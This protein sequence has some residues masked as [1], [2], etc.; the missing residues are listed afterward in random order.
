MPTTRSASAS[1]APTNRF[2]R[3]FG[4]PSATTTSTRCQVFTFE[5]YKAPP[6]PAPAQHQTLEQ[7]MSEWEQDEEWR[8]AMAEARHWVADQFYAED[9]DTVRTLRLRKGWSQSRLAEA[10]GTS[11]SHVA[12]IERGTENLALETC[13][14][15]CG[16]LGIDMNTL[17]SALKR[18]EAIARATWT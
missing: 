18:Q 9:G 11:Q 4:Q 6:P 15:L 2:E 16:A 3:T 5:T 7:L 17:D 13:R 12:R 8:A 10:L 14:K 1:S